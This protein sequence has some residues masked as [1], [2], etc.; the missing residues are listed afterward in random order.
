MG[1][2]RYR[3][4]HYDVF[5]DRR[6][7]GNQLAVFPEAAGLT[8]QTMQQIAREIGFAETTFVTAAE[9][10]D[11]DV[12]MRIFTPGTEMP[13]AGHPVVGST[14]ALAR[15]GAIAA[16]R[17]EWVFGLNIGPT[18]VSM[19]WSGSRLD[20]AWMTQ[21]QPEFGPT[22]DDTARVA[23]ALGVDEHDIRATEL[24]VQQVSCGVP[25]VFVPVATRAAVDR[26]VPDTRLLDFEA[27]LF[28]IDRAGATDSAT[29]YSRMFAPALNVYEDPATGSASGPLGCYLVR[30]S[31]VTSEE[32]RSILNLQGVKLGR[33]SWIHVSIDSSG[34]DISRVRVG[35][36]SVFVAEG[37]MEVED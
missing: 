31:L 37:V 36:A 29:T 11:T 26:A 23:T 22:F 21:R 5:T 7:G 33:P 25:F 18:P 9:R 6:F 19:E 1:I 15:D 14:F 35:G 17:G 12:R 10:P 3:Y 2:S 8:A 13:M 24:P 30:H 20:F 32:G 4:L 34:G 16:G 27:Y 28:T